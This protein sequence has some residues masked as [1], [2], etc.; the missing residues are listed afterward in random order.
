VLYARLYYPQIADRHALVKALRR[1]HGG[2]LTE[3]D[4]DN[5]Y[6][7]K[8][9]HG[10]KVF[11]DVYI[12]V[13]SSLALDTLPKN[14]IEKYLADL[15]RQINHFPALINWQVTVPSCARNMRD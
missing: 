9:S 6:A 7:F 15:K 12:K 4:L 8:I 5:L 1:E 13:G 11:Q 2:R 10:T 14:H 3:S